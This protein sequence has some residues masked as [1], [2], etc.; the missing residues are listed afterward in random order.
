MHMTT[1]KEALRNG[2]FDIWLDPQGNLDWIEFGG[3]YGC[4]LAHLVDAVCMLL[5]NGLLSPSDTRLAGAIAIAH[6]RGFGSISD[7]P[8]TCD[9]YAYPSAEEQAR[10]ENRLK[11]AHAAH[12]AYLDHLDFADLKAR[13]KKQGELKVKKFRSWEN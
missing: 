11:A 2:T 5:E 4:A 8:M 10:D 7:A 9:H 3:E 6:Q 13:I 12:Q 1:I